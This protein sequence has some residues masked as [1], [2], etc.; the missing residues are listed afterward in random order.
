MG[1]LEIS[2]NIVISTLVGAASGFCAFK[3]LGRKWVENW[4]AK[5]LKQYEHKLDILK[6]KDE[7]RFNI[8][9]KERID[10]IKKLYKMVFE[11]NESV[12]HIMMPMNMQEM[13]QFKED[14]VA[15]KNILKSH[16][17]QMYLLSNDIYIPKI[18]VDRIAGVCYT[19][20]S[21]T[22][23]IME[24]NSDD[25]KKRLD[26][27]YIKKVRPLLDDL[28]NEFRRLLGVEFYDDEFMNK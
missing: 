18:L 27:F 20:D 22:K 14:D 7:I 8:L 23:R 15:K 2:I 3:Y 28:R 6:I 26:D 24:D 4:F 5:D 12:L 13:I 9:H 11:L 16:N 17:V 10:I 1:T 19:F 21:I 25:N